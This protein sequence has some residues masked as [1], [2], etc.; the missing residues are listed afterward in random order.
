MRPVP[1]VSYGPLDG[2]VVWADF[3]RVHDMQ[4]VDDAWCLTAVQT[5]WERFAPL[6]L[7]R[8]TTINPGWAGPHTPRGKGLRPGEYLHAPAVETMDAVGAE[9]T[10]G[11]TFAKADRNPSLSAANVVWVKALRGNQALPPGWWGN[12]AAHEAG[13]CLL[14]SAGPFAGAGEHTSDRG[15]V[16]YGNPDGWDT[17]APTWSDYQTRAWAYQI[18]FLRE[19]G[20]RYR[21][22]GTGPI[23]VDDGGR[24]AW[25][26]QE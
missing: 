26:L 5:L 12:C 2:Y 25:P 20:L 13:H 16:M 23:P 3:Y 14:P 1:T 19:K 10:G 24:P 17:P 18:P 21:P 6:G 4:V 8:V 22:D 9:G 15:N 7:F 11:Y